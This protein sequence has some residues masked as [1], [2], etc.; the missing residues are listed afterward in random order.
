M[1]FVGPGECAAIIILLS[2]AVKWRQKTY[3][4]IKEAATVTD[5]ALD[6]L[7]NQGNNISL[8]VPIAEDS[9]THFKSDCASYNSSQYEA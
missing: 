2:L 4:Y 1:K 6:L 8:V 3:S 9:E 5:H 7:C